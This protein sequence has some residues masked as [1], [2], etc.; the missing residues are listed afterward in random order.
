MNAEDIRLHIR[1]FLVEHYPTISP[2][3]GDEEPLL[4]SRAVDSLGIVKLVTFVES[5]FDITIADE[6]FVPEHF[7][8]IAALA[9][10]VAGKLDN[11]QQSD[12][13]S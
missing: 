9:A 11:N 4:G 2:T 1:K 10:F 6:E 13:E 8:S 7:R 3:L 5:E 12:K